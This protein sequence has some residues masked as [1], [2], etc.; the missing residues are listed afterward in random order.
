MDVTSAQTRASMLFLS[1]ALLLVAP[2]TAS[3]AAS[4]PAR[5]ARSQVVVHFARGV[6]PAR[7][8]S[9]LAR[10]GV[11]VVRSLP[12]LR[13]I[14]GRVRAGG[15]AA[16][17]TALR[18]QPGVEAAP[19]G[20][21]HAALVPTDPF[22]AQWS[23]PAAVSGLEQAWDV[24][25]G[26]PSVTIAIVDTGVAPLPDLAPAL[27]P[28]V[29]LVE[30]GNGASDPNGHGTQVASIAAA[31]TNNGVGIAG[32]CG[33]CSIMPVRVLDATGSGLMSTVAAGV[34]WA[35]EHG[36]NVVN[37]S[38]AGSVDSPV[39]DAAIAE[40]TARGVTVVI[41]AGNGGSADPAQSGYPAAASPSAIRVAGAD[42]NGALF[43]W[44]NHGG[45]VDLAA[46]GNA[47]TLL[48]N[49]FVGLGVQGTSVATPFVAGAAGLLLSRNPGLAPAAVK[50]DLLTGGRPGAVDVASGKLLDAYGA[51]QAAGYTTPATPV[52]APAPTPSPT[53]TPVRTIAQ[54]PAASAREKQTKAPA[55]RTAAERTRAARLKTRR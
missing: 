55:R 16:A 10:A 1:L 33:N 26:S 2:A 28:G 7:Q 4:A 39:L 18:H 53:T 12:G 35:V 40:A 41:A 13:S 32:V 23:W 29:D 5:A 31:R 3:A 27:V 49:G 34:S 11:D 8:R 54:P 51:L 43:P 6:A 48:T 14:V 30:A 9:I 37:L 20:V 50:Q 21:A 24:S 42:E 46:P 44:S 25:L 52:T 45:W 17:L 36:A 47:E 38:L 22:F 15:R 19:D